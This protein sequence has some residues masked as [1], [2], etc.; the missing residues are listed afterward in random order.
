MAATMHTMNAL[1]TRS[2]KPQMATMRQT[3]FQAS[4][5]AAT[6]RSVI[7]HRSA[8]FSVRRTKNLSR[9]SRLIIAQTGPKNDL[10][11]EDQDLYSDSISSWEEL[12]SVAS[13]A[14][15]VHAGAGD[16]PAVCRIKGAETIGPNSTFECLEPAGAV[17]H[18]SQMLDGAFFNASTVV[19]THYR[20]LKDCM[21]Q[22]DFDL[23]SST[24]HN[25]ANVEPVLEER[26]VQATASV[27][28]E[29]LETLKEEHL[30]VQSMLEEQIAA[31]SVDEEL[32]QEFLMAN[33][34]VQAVDK[35]CAMLLPY[36]H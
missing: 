8:V 11:V 36:T 13:L 7:G 30:I 23:V 21:I 31:G 34:I 16:I 17:Q 24:Y 29:A 12:R 22:E 33:S 26:F 9:A 1:V 2:V 32:R 27:A 3:M 18:F 4:P 19:D 28:I 25:L 14:Y 15:A 5:S 20:L 10:A 6:M 35:V